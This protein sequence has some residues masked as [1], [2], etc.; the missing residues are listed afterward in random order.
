V[1][2]AASRKT[3]SA[4]ERKINER[5]IR[6]LKAVSDAFSRTASG[7]DLAKEARA[8]ERALAAKHPRKATTQSRVQSFA[9]AAAKYSPP[10]RVKKMA[11]KVRWR[12]AAKKDFERHVGRPAT[13]EIKKTPGIIK[14]EEKN[15]QVHYKTG[16]FQCLGDY[17]ACCQQRS[18]KF[19]AP[20][21]AVCITHQLKILQA[22]GITA[23]VAG[24]LRGMIGH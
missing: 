11:K 16:V 23:G 4:K 19:C 6:E 18:W 2:K 10:G 22:V 8:L 14:R 17:E 24:G 20:W 7:S 15:K 21:L 13:P 3:T 5:A 9:R 12:T 1:A